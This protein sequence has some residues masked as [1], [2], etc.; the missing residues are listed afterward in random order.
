MSRILN[1]VRKMGRFIF[2]RYTTASSCCQIQK[3]VDKMNV[4]KYIWL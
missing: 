3:S 4:S 1:N 2:R